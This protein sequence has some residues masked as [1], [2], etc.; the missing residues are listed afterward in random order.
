M[1]ARSSCTAR[2]ARLR[3]LPAL[4]PSCILMPWKLCDPGGNVHFVADTDA[5][6]AFATARGLKT[7]NMLELV[8]EGRERKTHVPTA[9]A[10]IR[11]TCGESSRRSATSRDLAPIT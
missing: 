2:A 9:S 1:G 3:C 10:R 5:M 7:G 6:I 8:G 11:P 4:L